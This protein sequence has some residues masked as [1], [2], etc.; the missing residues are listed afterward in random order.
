[1]K[2]MRGFPHPACLAPDICHTGFHAGSPAPAHCPAAETQESRGLVRRTWAPSGH[3]APA[4]SSAY[5]NALPSI[6]ARPVR[7]FDQRRSIS[8]PSHHLGS[9]EFLP[10]TPAGRPAGSIRETIPLALKIAVKPWHVLFQLAEDEIAPILSEKVRQRHGRE[11][12]TLARVTD[13]ELARRNLAKSSLTIGIADVPGSLRASSAGTPSTSGLVSPSTKPKCSLGVILPPICRRPRADR[14][15]IPV[16]RRQQLP[17]RQ[18]RA[19]SAVDVLPYI[20]NQICTRCVFHGSSH[21]SGELSQTSPSSFAR[22]FMPC[23]NSAGKLARLSSGNPKARR[24]SKVR[25]TLSRGV[26]FHAP[27]CR[28]SQS[29]RS[30]AVAGAL[31]HRPHYGCSSTGIVH[32]ERTRSLAGCCPGYSKDRAW[33]GSW[34]SLCVTSLRRPGLA[35]W[36]LRHIRLKPR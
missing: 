22:R 7:V 2:I 24:P 26:R 5:A 35:F 14:V 10:L 34:S 6:V 28:P 17:E 25:A 23:W 8:P 27:L 30:E 4:G 21:L 12:A 13:N 16:R 19:W 32:A 31:W 18:Q 9:Q 29:R 20:M 11:L 15:P 1:M 36:R 33:C 3:R